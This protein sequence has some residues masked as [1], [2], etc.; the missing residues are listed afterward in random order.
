MRCNGVPNPPDTPDFNIEK[1]VVGATGPPKRCPEEMVP[2]PAPNIE[3]G[4]ARGR[5]LWQRLQKTVVKFR[6]GVYAGGIGVRKGTEAKEGKKA[7]KVRKQRKE[8]R[9]E[10]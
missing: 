8:A 1:Y 9:Y 6:S 4:C 3:I 2:V 10:R 5:V 7:R